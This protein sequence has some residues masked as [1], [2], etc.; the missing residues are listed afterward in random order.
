MVWVPS[1]LW[2]PFQQPLMRARIAPPWHSKE[3]A[4]KIFG[5]KLVVFDG[6]GHAFN[7]EIPERFSKAVLDFVRKH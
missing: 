5:V 7:I 3:L 4:E 6:G 1:K 2:E